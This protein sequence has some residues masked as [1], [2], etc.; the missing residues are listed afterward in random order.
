M[1]AMSKLALIVK[2]RTKPGARDQL[3]DLYLEHLAPRTEASQ[4][5]EAVVLCFDGQDPD[6]LYLF[7]VYRDQDALQQPPGRPGSPS[8]WAGRPPCSRGSRR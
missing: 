5:Q 4:D 6:V 8:T 3:R 2:T 1:R 7:E